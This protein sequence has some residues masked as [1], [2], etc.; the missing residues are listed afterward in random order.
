MGYFWI[1]EDPVG[2]IFGRDPP[3]WLVGIAPAGQGFTGVGDINGDGLDDVAIGA[4]NWDV[5]GTRGRVVILSGDSGLVVS[6]YEYPVPKE[7]ELSVIAYPNPFNASTRIVI[8]GLHSGETFQL[9]I[10]N[11]LGQEVENSEEKVM[12][13]S[14]DYIWDASHNGISLPGGVYFCH[15]RTASTNQTVKLLLVR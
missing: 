8:D 1:N 3:L 6:A 12:G 2:M 14:Y 4:T 7:Y 15:V 5:D 11:I 9:T 13:Y 10:Y